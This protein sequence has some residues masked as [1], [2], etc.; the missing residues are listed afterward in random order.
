[1]SE[2]KQVV[3]LRVGIDTGSGG[4]LGPIFA[5]GSF[6]FIPIDAAHDCLR[7]TYGNTRGR[8]GRKLIEYFRDGK[9]KERMRTGFLH[10][11]PEFDSYTYG[12]PTAPKQSLKK[13]EPGNLLV[14][15]AGLKGWG[16]CT[17]PK[18]LYI[19][20]YFVVERAGTY[21]ELERDGVIKRFAKNWHILNGDT[22][23]RLI[24]RKRKRRVHLVLIAGGRGSRLLK[25]AVRISVE[26]RDRNGQKVYVLAPAM[27]R[28]FGTFTKLNAIQRSTPRPVSEEFC[29]KAEKFV[30]AL[31]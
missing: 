24:G 21:T 13:L 9:H 23:G 10:N 4:I 3:L 7:R 17:T 12:D 16:N 2:F 15:Y 11:D 29:E 5:N 1:M 31:K 19:I 14:L 30:M 26:G 18:G 20:G 8:H 22:R 6:E 28:H 25:K 27:K